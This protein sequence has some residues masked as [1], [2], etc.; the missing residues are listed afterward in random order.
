[1]A[2]RIS[3][4]LSHGEARRFGLLVGAAFA[5]LGGLQWWRGRP[6]FALVLGALG[7]VLLVLGVLLPGALVPVRRWWM[8]MAT[9]ISKVTTPLFMAVVYFAV[10]T[11]VGMVRRLIGSSPLKSRSSGD[12][13]WV[14]RGLGA[15]PPEEMEHQ[16]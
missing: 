6:S 11:P 8:G 5:V 1:M 14:A 7:S 15:R 9:G 12:S 10:L 2:E 4:G 13:R 3:A 16:F